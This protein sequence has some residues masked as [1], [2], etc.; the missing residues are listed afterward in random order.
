MN[1]FKAILALALSLS[2]ALPGLADKH[3]E[4]EE[5]DR[6]LHRRTNTEVRSFL[7]EHFPEPL[8]DLRHAE[9]K[10]DVDAV[11]KFW[12][13]AR[14]FIGELHLTRE[15][16]GEH[17]ADALLV[18]RRTE[19]VADRLTEHFH[20][21]EG[22]DDVQLEI[23]SELHTVLGLHHKNRLL[24]EEMKL[25]RA[26]DEL[27][28]SAQ[29]LKQL[30]ERTEMILNDELRKRLSGDHGGSDEAG[31]EHD[32]EKKDEPGENG[33]AENRKKKDDEKR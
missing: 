24:I 13:E 19:F 2:F 9:E 25:E 23:K 12:H 15:E 14:E 32:S 11:E 18:M 21:A 16:L 8:K 26:R 20:D 1:P 4:K 5:A 10:G 33:D 29:E 3:E 22:D 30:T 6:P 17:A 31:E 28:R 27:E 7:K